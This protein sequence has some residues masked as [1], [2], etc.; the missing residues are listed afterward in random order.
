MWRLDLIFTGMISHL[1]EAFPMNAK[2]SFP[3]TLEDFICKWGAPD[4][5]FSDNAWEQTSKSVMDILHHYNIGHHHR[6]EPEQQNQNPAEHRI[7]DIK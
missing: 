6:S 7:Q 4:G 1:T 5:L 2:S 3:E